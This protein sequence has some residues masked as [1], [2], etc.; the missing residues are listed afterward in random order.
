LTAAPTTGEPPAATGAGGHRPSA[1]CGRSPDPLSALGHERL[2]DPKLLGRRVE[3]RASQ[4]EVTAVVLDTG[5]VERPS[6]GTLKR[7]AN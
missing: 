7:H 3:V 6:N 4:R 5:E 1:L 2:L